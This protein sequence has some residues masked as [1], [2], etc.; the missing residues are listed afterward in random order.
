MTFTPYPNSPI[1]SLAQAAAEQGDTEAPALDEVVDL[2]FVC[3][4]HK[5][6]GLYELDGRKSFPIFHGPAT[7][8][9]LLQDSAKVV[10][11]FIDASQSINFNL[12]AFGAAAPQ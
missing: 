11:K 1:C 7:Q 8:E 3:F 9:T 12:I 10:Q 2:H 6:G 5:E 4:V